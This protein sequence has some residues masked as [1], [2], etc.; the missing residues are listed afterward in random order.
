MSAGWFIAPT[1]TFVT[2][3]SG[4]SVTFYGSVNS[5]NRGFYLDSFSNAVFEHVTIEQIKKQE[6]WTTET[7]GVVSCESSNTC[8]LRTNNS[9]A[10]INLSASWRVQQDNEREGI[11]HAVNSSRVYLRT[12]T[13]SASS[14]SLIIKDGTS[15]IEI[16]STTKLTSCLINSTNNYNLMDRRISSGYVS[17]TNK[18]SYSN[19]EIATFS[20]ITGNPNCTLQSGVITFSNPCVVEVIVHGRG[21]T[22][23]SFSFGLNGAN[24]NSVGIRESSVALLNVNSGDKLNFSSSSTTTL[25]GTGGVR[26]FISPSF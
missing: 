8:I 16:S 24:D 11:I 4:N 6:G 14:L 1:A 22:A 12:S 15:K 18:T 21:I 20:S 10:D 25:S 26:V 13:V 3:D 23:G 2:D 17:T 5:A 9:A 19:G 7:Y